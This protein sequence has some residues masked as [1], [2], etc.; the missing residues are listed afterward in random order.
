MVITWYIYIYITFVLKN[1]Y[2]IICILLILYIYIRVAWTSMKTSS[3]FIDA[4]WC[5]VSPTSQ[6]S[7][8][9]F[10][11]HGIRKARPSKYLKEQNQNE[12]EKIPADDVWW[13]LFVLLRGQPEGQREDKMVSLDPIAKTEQKSRFTLNPRYPRSETTIYRLWFISFSGLVSPHL[14]IVIYIYINW[15]NVHQFGKMSFS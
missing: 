4:S 2:L 9:F 14:T 5:I 6:R 13:C 8:A 15:R 7:S 1:I 10:E 3:I 12:L 11:T